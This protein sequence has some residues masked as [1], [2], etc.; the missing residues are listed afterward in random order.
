MCVVLGVE[1]SASTELYPFFFL[2]IL[3]QCLANLLSSP[4]WTQAYDFPATA[5]QSAGVPGAH[6]HTWLKFTFVKC[7]PVL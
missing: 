2:I 3:R 1:P 7:C 6:L 5:S 4:G